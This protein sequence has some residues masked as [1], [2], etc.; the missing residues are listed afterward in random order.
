M[1]FYIDNN[2]NYYE[3]DKAEFSDAEVLQRPD[4][5]YKWIGGVWQI[6]P[7]II[8]NLTMRQ[9]RLGLFT[10]GLLASVEAVITTQEQRIWW[11]Y[12]VIVERNNPLVISV[13]ATLG[14]TEID[15]D[16]MFVRAAQL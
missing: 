12:S 7:A 6:T 8:P 9:A 11:E 3:G 5:N 13:L 16:N 4:C 10:D 15:I 1:G 14:K 2:N